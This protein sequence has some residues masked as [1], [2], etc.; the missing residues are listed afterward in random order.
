MKI[1]VAT[2]FPDLY[3]EFLKTSLV[4][5]AHEKGVVKFDVVGFSDFCTPKERLDG[6]AVGHGSG[7]VIRPEV[8]ERI[9]DAQEDKHGKA[10]K[11]F[12]T[13]QGK[14]FDQ[15]MARELATILKDKKHLMLVAGR[16]EGIDQRAQSHYADKEV[17]IGDYVLMGGDLPAMVLIE[18][19][20][21]Y[22][23][24][25]VGKA[26]SVEEDSFSGPFIDYPTYTVPP[27]EWKDKS[28]PEVLFSGNHAE[29]KKWREEISI[30]RSVREHFEWLRSH[31]VSMEDRKKA[32]SHIPPHYIALLHD[33]VVVKG[34]RVGTSSVTSLDIHDIARS[35]KT[36]G[37]KEY[38]LV[39]PLN[40]QQKIVKKIL[41]FWRNGGIEYNKQRSEA[42]KLLTVEPSL[43]ET[44]KAIEQKEGKRPLIIAT[45]A[46]S[47]AEAPVITYKDQETV[48]SKD[49]PILFIFGTAQGLSSET[50]KRCDYVLLPLEGFSEFN[51]LSVRSAVA[52]ILDRWLGINLSKQN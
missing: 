23:P 40:D 36:Y 20:L 50:I 41:E 4:N 5:R 28:V 38:F 27:H 46:R 6:S 8:L 1:S 49:Q 48:W 17:S 12:L 18:S 33:D 22:V 25:V 3:S 37:I 51:H 29:I 43:D 13:P 19:F 24:G 16:Y 45:S 9:V 10:F 42:V 52:I 14:K 32:G 31:C 35:A 34:G 44:I 2:V 11:I 7:M 30:K 47:V 26:E 21:R 39:T 15:N